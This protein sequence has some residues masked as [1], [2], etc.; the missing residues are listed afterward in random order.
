MKKYDKEHKY[1]VNRKTLCVK[2]FKDVIHRN[3]FHEYFKPFHITIDKV[4]YTSDYAMLTFPS[5]H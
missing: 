3:D 1:L 4:E 2:D 5:S